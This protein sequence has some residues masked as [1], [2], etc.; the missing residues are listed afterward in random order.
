MFSCFL[1]SL[2][3][4]LSK[5]RGDL[6]SAGE[7]DF[8]TGPRG[9]WIKVD[10]DEIKRRWWLIVQCVGSRI[11]K[12]ECHVREASTRKRNKE[13]VI[14]QRFNEWDPARSNGDLTVGGDS[15]KEEEEMENGRKKKWKMGTWKKKGRN[16]KKKRDRDRDSERER[17]IAKW[18]KFL[19]IVVVV[20]GRWYKTG[21]SMVWTG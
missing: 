1:E 15:G 12:R 7:S 8:A 21:K 3:F 13:C 11:G 5:F 2:S 20:V 4:C 16:E 6:C 17:E 19:W 18:K 14:K 9:S 10:F